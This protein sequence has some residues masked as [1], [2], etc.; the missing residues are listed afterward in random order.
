MR[1]SFR[2]AAMRCRMSRRPWPRTASTPSAF[3]YWAPDLWD[4]P[5][6]FQTPALDGGWYRGAGPRRLSQLRQSL[7]ARA[8]SQQPVRTATLAYDAVALVAALVKTQ[9]AQR[10][11]P[12]VLTNPSGFTGHRRAVPLPPRRHQRARAC[13]HA[14]HALRGAQ[15]IQ[16]APRSFG[17]AREGSCQ[18]GATNFKPRDRRPPHRAPENP[19]A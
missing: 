18:L 4:D 7:R 2:T 12:E 1:C 10:F 3:S 14:G 15:V 17:P 16:A 19:A 13:D 9:G 6:V 8:S 11:S 5:R